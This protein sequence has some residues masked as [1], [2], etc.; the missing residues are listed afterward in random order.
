VWLT[1]DIDIQKKTEKTLYQSL[2]AIRRDEGSDNMRAGSAIV[3]E[4]GT[5]DVIAIANY[6]SYDPAEFIGGIS[7]KRWEQLNDPDANNPLQNRAI[8]SAYP[9]ASTFKSIVS[10]ALLENDM[11]NS[12]RSFQCQG[13]WEG[14]GADWPRHCWNRGGHGWKNMT[15]AIAVSCNVYFYE[16]GKAFYNDFINDENRRELLQDE[17]RAF[18]YGSRT[19][20]DIPGEVAGRVPDAQ[21]KRDWNENYP[22][23]QQWL[24]G[25]TVSLAIGQGDML[26]TP[27][28]VANSYATIANGGTAITPRL[29]KQITDGLGEVV[30][31]AEPQES[32][33][34]PSAS[35]A[36]ISAVQRG[37]REVIT[38]G[39]GRNAFNNFSV[40]V[41]GKT[42]T[43][44]IGVAV[45]GDDSTANELSWFVGYA[46]ANNPKYL[47]LV[48][49]EESMGDVSVSAPAAR[50][51]LG[52]L[53]GK[54]EELRPVVDR[55]R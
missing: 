35:A 3:L 25:D 52:A 31:R 32:E 26:A 13:R 36:D 10:M 54:E 30:K 41:A 1:I 23:F 16:A 45:Q 2:D 50:V 6:P 44:Q 18:G 28:Q 34:Q 15:E 17:L 51:I 22:E 46:P 5:G 9:P 42:G 53:F 55:S 33:V 11:W 39:T 48:L 47:V 12:N 24:P 40:D 7:T 27:L 49:I 20:I 37:L 38:S 21:W 19:G 8:S 14:L 4:I 43:A 29:L